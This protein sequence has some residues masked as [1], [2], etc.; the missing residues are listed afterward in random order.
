MLVL[1]Y[2]LT[3]S[4]WLECV[5]FLICK[6]LVTRWWGSRVAFSHAVQSS[7]RPR[8]DNKSAPGV[9]GKLFTPPYCTWAQHHAG[10]AQLLWLFLLKG[11]IQ[12]DLLICVKDIITAASGNSPKLIKTLKLSSVLLW[13]S[14]SP[15]PQL[16]A[17][18]SHYTP[19][20]VLFSMRSFDTCTL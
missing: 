16:Y 12:A 18:K 19:L 7:W 5:N 8:R 14:Q 17:L 15:A 20:C 2:Y 6:K 9:R 3:K 1:D 13:K 4:L 11:L 10:G